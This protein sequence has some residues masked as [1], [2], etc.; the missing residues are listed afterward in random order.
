MTIKITHANHLFDTKKYIA[1]ASLFAATT[2][3]FHDV[4]LK[5]HKVS[6]PDALRV[7]L[8]AKLEQLPK[9]DQ[10]A[11]TQRLLL[12]S[13]LL[14]GWLGKLA[15]LEL[16]SQSEQDKTAWEAEQSIVETDVRKF[17]TDNC[18]CTTFSQA[19][20]LTHHKTY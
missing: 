3:S 11:Q 19:Y 6:E 13:W 16:G 18:V 10:F 14:E 5:F 7:Y 9:N 17:L 12:S 20:I 8:F 15:Q 1:S 4:V 2:M